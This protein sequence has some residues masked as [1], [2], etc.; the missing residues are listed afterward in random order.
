MSRSISG[1]VSTAVNAAHVKVFPLV[2]MALDSG[3]VYVCGAAHDVVYNSNTY[4]ALYGL[5]S[6][7][8]IEE[9]DSMVAGLA[10]TLSGVPSSIIATTL[11]TEVQGRACVVRM[12]F[13]DSSNAL[14]VDT[15]VWTGYLDQMT[16]EDGAPTATVRVTAEHRLV[17]WDTPRPWRFSNE[18]QQIISAG[19]G[20]FKWS[21]AIAEATLVWP[22]REWFKAH[23]NDPL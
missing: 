14:Q 15:N 11:A 6:I 19:D 16:L 8:P 4:Q 7:E 5:G 2:E 18:D 12:A 23:A 21:A 22:N 17:R 10:F 13:I 20:F 1:A 9:T 3:T